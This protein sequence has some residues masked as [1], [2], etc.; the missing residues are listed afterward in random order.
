MKKDIAIELEGI[1]KKYRISKVKNDTFRDQ[2]VSWV[3]SPL[4]ILTQEKMDEFWA[5]KDVSFSVTEGEVVGI[6]GKNGSGKSTLLKI[7][8][9][10]TEP[11]TGRAKL[12]GRVSS[13][14]EVGTGFNPEL[15]GREN[16]FFNGSILGMSRQE[17]RKKF[18]EIVDFSGVEK[19]IDTPVKRYSSGMRVRLAFAVAAHL[20]SEIL[21]IDEVLAVGD[22]NFQEK[23][24][25][26]VHD[27]AN[28]GRTVLFV[29][30][31]MSAVANFCSRA[32]Y[33]KNGKVSSLGK[34]DRIVRDYLDDMFDYTQTNL[35]DQIEGPLKDSVLLESVRVNTKDK[36]VFIKPSEKI[37]IE[38]KGKCLKNSWPYRASIAVFREGVRL[39]T[40][41]D[42]QKPI[43]VRRGRF[44]SRVSIPAY[45]LRPG[46]YSLAVG[47]HGAS[48]NDWMFGK[49]VATFVVEEFYDI[50]NDAAA[51]G[52]VNVVYDSERVEIGNKENKI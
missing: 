33:L 15:T 35:L 20:E 13:L 44:A 43:E 45:T 8:S 36:D 21:L 6:I 40:L 11:T 4:S 9:Q 30:H 16:V 31:N 18:D 2:L 19:F 12:R 42:T 14:L 49:D 50:K 52:L 38:L 28:S 7:L 25:G 26:K 39:F 3:K 17:I 27:M 41:H 51:V 24:L 47:G 29:S 34:T 32:V 5:L 48:G 10:I 37:L 1:G 46:R 22:I 23:S